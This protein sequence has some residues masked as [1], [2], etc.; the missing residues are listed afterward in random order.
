MQQYA[1]QRIPFATEMAQP[2]RNQESMRPQAQAGLSTNTPFA[3][4][5]NM[6]TIQTINDTSPTDI[7]LPE[8]HTDSSDDSDRNV[9]LPSWATPGHVFNTLS[10]QETIN[11]DAIFPRIPTISMDDVFAANPDRLT[12]LRMRTSSANWVR[13]GDALTQVEVLED[14]IGREGIR[15]LGGWFYGAGNGQ[16]GN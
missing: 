15:N 6:H 4:M 14:R 11:P 5:R 7:T 13:T 2:Q 12:R 1:T 16:N 10:Q 3:P 9:S 8:I